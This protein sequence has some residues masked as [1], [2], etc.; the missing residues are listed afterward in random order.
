MKK[1]ILFFLSVTVAMGI[2]NYT[3]NE[4]SKTVLHPKAKWKTFIK[5]NESVIDSHNSTNEELLAAKIPPPIEPTKTQRSIA[6]VN[7][8]QGFM[9]RSNRIIMG[10]LDK[11]YGDENNELKMINTINPEWK[12]LMGNEMMRFQSTDT[13]VIVKE[14]VPVIKVINGV[15]RFLEQ[16]TVTYLIKDGNR[17][18]FKALVDSETGT[19]VQTWDRTIHE[20]L[21]TKRGG[22]ILPSINESGIITK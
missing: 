14:D 13:K 21:K 17:N 3:K 8:Y 5:K 10:D 9:I 6:S 22:I 20:N 15:G 1:A 4:R 11:N 2:T 16:V 18:S 19:I 7:P 12:E